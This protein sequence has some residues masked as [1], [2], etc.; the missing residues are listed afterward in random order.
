MNNPKRMLSG[1]FSPNCTP[2]INDKVDYYGIEKNIEKLN[3]S[4]LKG[5]FVLGTNGE[6]KAL[7]ESEK[8]KVLKTYIK[9][10]CDNKIIMAGTGCE[11]TYETIKMTKK[12]ADMGAKLVSLLM[13]NFFVNKINADVMVSHI[14]EVADNSPVPVVLYNNPSVAAGVTITTDVI[15]RVKD[16]PSVAGLKTVQMTHGLK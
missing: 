14:I 2:F 16:H 9:Y 15:K 4:E 6:F 8:F 1:V 5:Y 13:P 10:S 12:A 7:T 3:R 11:S